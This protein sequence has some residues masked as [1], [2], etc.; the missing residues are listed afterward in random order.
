VA[1]GA[2]LIAQIIDNIASQTIEQQ[3]LDTNAGK[4]QS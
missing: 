1:S 2:Y 4:Q 3:V